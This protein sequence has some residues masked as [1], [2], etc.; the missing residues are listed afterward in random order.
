GAKA[1]SAYQKPAS[2]ILKTDLATAV[3]TSLGK[4]DS[5]VQSVGLAS[6]TNNGTVKLTVGGTATDNIAVK[7]LGSAAYTA[8]TAYATA[9]QGVKADSALQS[10]SSLNAAKLTGTVPQASLPKASASAYGV[11]KMSLS[12]TV[13]T[14]TTN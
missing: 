1:D 6:G 3:Q 5:A 12:G 13:L 8:S 11:A 7:G 9:A 4:A 10:A 14:I 2:G